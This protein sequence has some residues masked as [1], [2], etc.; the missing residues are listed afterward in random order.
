MNPHATATLSSSSP[1]RKT[2][3]IRRAVTTAV[4]GQI[5]EWYDFFLY[6]T[7][8]ALVFGKLF[9]PVGSDPLT[10]TIAAFGGFTV[11]FI[12]RPVGGVLC[13]H[14]GDRYGRKTVMMLTLLTMGVATMCMGL[15]PTYQQIGIAAPIAL[16]LLRILQ[17]LA[18]GGEWSGSIL[19]IHESA[20]ASRRGALAAWSPSGAAFGF[21][22]STAAFLL[23]QTLSPYDFLSWGWRVPFLCSVVL[24]V[25]GLWMRRSVEESAD[26]VAVKATHRESRMP[27]VEVLRR[28]PRQVL[29]V[30]GLRFG[31]GGASYIFF[32]F[33]IAYGQ[34]LGLKSTWILGGLTLSMLL[35]IP[36]SLLMGHL[37][38]KIGRKPV[39][40]AGAIAMVLVAYPYFTLLASGV[41]WKVIAALIL[42]NSVTLGILEGAQPAFISELLPVHLRFS[43]LGIG[44][45]ISSVLGGGLSPMIATALLAH[46]RSAT[47]VAIYLV[48][49][50][51]VTVI[52]TCI[53]PETFPRAA[54]QQAKQGAEPVTA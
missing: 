50:A 13:G 25:L 37:T 49:L 4:L 47:P 45:E 23:A 41:L 36:M 52:A 38:D 51:L 10:G 42:A 31:E 1:L 39:Y 46:Y 3:T 24:V 5:L 22:L 53:A 19:M 6:G 12:A 35:M 11:G 48:A 27:I 40:L 18:A 7:A 43:G 28:C 26:F 29:T 9:F 8:A 20:P 2:S 34:F 33:S 17:G 54:R 21:V 32:A 14:I 30:F 15:L 44:R 16:V